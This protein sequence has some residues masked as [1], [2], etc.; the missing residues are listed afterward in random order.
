MKKAEV[1][2]YFVVEILPLLYLGVKRR[3]SGT[4]TQE[5]EVTAVPQ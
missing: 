5:T 1:S 3:H 2:S 4:E